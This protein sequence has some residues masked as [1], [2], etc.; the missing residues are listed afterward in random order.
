MNKKSTHT[1][2]TTARLHHIEALN[3]YIQ[4][5][6]IDL[7][8]LAKRFI[9]VGYGKVLLTTK[10]GILDHEAALKKNTGGAIVMFCY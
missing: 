3:K 5:K 6:T 4:T 2:T 7:E 8:N 10:K 1:Y 9:P